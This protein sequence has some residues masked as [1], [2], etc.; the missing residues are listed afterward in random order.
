MLLELEGQIK[1]TIED[2]CT[3]LRKIS[4][5]QSTINSLTCD[6]FFKKYVRP[7]P[8]IFIAMMSKHPHSTKTNSSPH[9]YKEVS[10]LFAKNEFYTLLER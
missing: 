9:Y 4:K 2:L 1:N 3:D 5:T 8:S 7:L 6:K 10:L